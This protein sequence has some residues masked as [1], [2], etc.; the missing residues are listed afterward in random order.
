MAPEMNKEKKRYLDELFG[1]LSAI[2]ED[3]YVFLCDMESDISKWSKSAVE[4]F[5][6]PDEYMKNAGGIWA[7]HIH[8]DDRDYYDLRVDRIFMGADTGLDLKYRARNREGRYLY[9]NCKGIVIRKSNGK[10]MY[11]GGV[12]KRLED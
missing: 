8:P 10:P 4:Y 11:F 1:A 12:I 5:G 2:A 7:E 9:C 3:A 6:L